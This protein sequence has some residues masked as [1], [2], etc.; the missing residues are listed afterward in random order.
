MIPGSI[1]TTDCR[2][3]NRSFLDLRLDKNG[4]ISTAFAL[5]LPVIIGFGGLA[6]DASH[7]LAAKNAA[8]GAA[9]SAA[10]SAV[11]AKVAGNNTSRIQNEAYAVAAL[12]GFVNGQGGVTVSLNN[13][14]LSGDYTTN[15]AAYEVI[16]TQSQASFLSR[17]FISA[18]VVTGRSVALAG[19]S[20][21]CIL[22]LS[23]SAQKSIGMSGGSTNVVANN[24]TVASN[25][26]SSDAVDL[27][28]GAM[29]TAGKFT[30]VG[31][32]QVSGS[33]TITAPIKNTYAAATVDPY[34][35]LAIPS[36]S[37]CDH[38]NYSQGN[39]AATI[40]PGVYCGGITVSGGGTLNMNPGTYI[41][42]GGS[43]NIQPG[44]VNASDV[45][46]VVTSNT[47]T[48]GVV[49][50]SG[51]SNVHISA[52]SSGAMRGVAIYVDRNDPVNT[53][54]ISGT[55]SLGVTGS[56]YMP[57]QNINY[58]GGSSNGNPCTQLI[59]LTITLSGGSSFGDSCGN[60]NVPGMM[61]SNKGIPVE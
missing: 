43:F 3:M 2:G 23:T 32:Y 38:I 52:P 30:E 5:T 27:S 34:A 45:S 8:Q 15:A 61:A 47:G 37:G 44:T 26:S 7:W 22:A 18:P 56:I 42:N 6:V 35:A 57:S 53:D 9:D 36:Y 50:I 51:T 48:W 33:S 40:N 46:V 12:D 16:I 59:A 10:L 17:L 54:N 25:S 13:P 21:A 60:L 29:L 20:P 39:V 49:N 41:V 11:A 55:S 31:N 1:F 24:C 58:S 19:S 4:A 28:G 14:P